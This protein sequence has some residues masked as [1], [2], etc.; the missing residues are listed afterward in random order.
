MQG[1]TTRT[2]RSCSRRTSKMRRARSQRSSTP[3]RPKSKHSKRSCAETHLER[4]AG[5]TAC[6]SRRRFQCA[7]TAR[8]A[9][10]RRRTAG[11]ASTTPRSSLTRLSRNARNKRRT[12]QGAS[13]LPRRRARTLLL[14]IKLRRPARPLRTPTTSGLV[15]LSTALVSIHLRPRTSLY[16][17]FLIKSSCPTL[18]ALSWIAEAC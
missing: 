9:G 11:T 3:S 17:L 15:S 10:T 2:R 16:K 18:Q 8:S 7:P 1:Q 5:A 14:V 12:S 6:L 4:N 13:L